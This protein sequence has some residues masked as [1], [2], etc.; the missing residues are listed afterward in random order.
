VAIDHRNT[1][2]SWLGS[3][4]PE[5]DRGFAYWVGTYCCRRCY[6]QLETRDTVRTGG[7]WGEDIGNSDSDSRERATGRSQPAVHSTSRE[8]MAP[9]RFGDLNVRRGE[10]SFFAP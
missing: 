5:L 3:W 9:T 4:A 8:R 6:C 10:E 2:G 7:C 1:A